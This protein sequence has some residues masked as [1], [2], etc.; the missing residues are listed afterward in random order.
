MNE[1]LDRLGIEATPVQDHQHH[2][3]VYLSPPKAEPIDTTR[4]LLTDML[5][6]SATGLATPPLTL[7]T[8]TQGL[9]DY[10]QTLTEERNHVYHGRAVCTGAGYPYCAG[11]SRNP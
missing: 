11:A 4:N 5:P 1:I 10:A 2:F 3:H 6:V 9:L 7:Q 8:E